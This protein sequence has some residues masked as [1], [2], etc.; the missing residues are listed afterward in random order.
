MGLFPKRPKKT[1]RKISIGLADALREWFRLRELRSAGQLSERDGARARLLED[2]LNT[3][4]LTLEASCDPGQDL[5]RNGI[6][7]VL[8]FIDLVAT[9]NCCEFP[10]PISKEKTR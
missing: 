8:E 3:V 2:G 10:R 4:R 9:T 5:N 6:D 1:T 7:D